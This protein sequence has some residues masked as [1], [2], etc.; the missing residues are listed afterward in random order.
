MKIY[1]PLVISLVLTLSS[2]NSN[3][4]ELQQSQ[5][6]LEQ[7]NDS[8]FNVLEKSWN[9]RTPAISKTVLEELDQWRQ[10]NEFS[11]ELKFKPVAST[12]AFQKKTEKLNTFVTALPAS[13]PGNL[14][15]PE[16]RA[17][18]TVLINSFN[19]LDMYLRLDPIPIE[20]ITPI[21]PQINKQ[22]LSITQKMDELLVKKSIPREVGE[23]EMLRALDTIR[24]ANPVTN[25]SSQAIT[26]PNITSNPSRISNLKLVKYDSI[27]TIRK[28]PDPK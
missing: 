7:Y 2:C 12:S 24:H 21:L 4:K 3:D 23:E 13:L 5:I 15:Q 25:H 11:D 28:K 17:R 1:I 22:L 19:L 26:S 8:V 9:F 18:F 16:I 20:E 27:S 6:K 14:D 10:W